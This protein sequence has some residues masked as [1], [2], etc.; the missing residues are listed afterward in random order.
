MDAELFTQVVN[1]QEWL[2]LAKQEGSL[3]HCERNKS[4][5]E[6][7]LTLINGQFFILMKLLNEKKTNYKCPSRPSPCKRTKRNSHLAI[8]YILEAPFPNQLIYELSWPNSE[9]MALNTLQVL[10]ALPPFFFLPAAYS[11][12]EEENEDSSEL[13]YL[14][15]LQSMICW[16]GRHY[17]TIM[18]VAFGP[19]KK[20]E[21]VLMNDTQIKKFE[22]WLEVVN[23]LLESGCCPTVIIYERQTI[24]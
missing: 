10:A 1:M 3:A 8:S 20:K 19:S 23:F 5:I 16:S 22:D 15:K 24:H 9:M 17:L 18:R 7:L 11:L 4:S 12:A 13:K 21:W 2:D 6:H 14:Y